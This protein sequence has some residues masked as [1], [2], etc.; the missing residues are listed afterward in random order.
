MR[1]PIKIISQEIIENYNLSDIVNDGWVYTKIVRGMY[2]LPQAGKIANDLL[3]KYWSGSDTMQPN[4]HQNCGYMCGDLSP[5]RW[6]LMILVSSL[7]E[8]L[9]P[10]ILSRLSKD[11]T[12]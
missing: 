3:K 7:K 9:T 5:S 11:T 12:T 6:S 2:G 1:L 10:T 4:S 8:T